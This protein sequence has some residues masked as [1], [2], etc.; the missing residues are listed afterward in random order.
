MSNSM[1]QNESPL[2]EII[3]FGGRNSPNV[4]VTYMQSVNQIQST[5]TNVF[6]K[7]T[8]QPWAVPPSYLQFAFIHLLPYAG[9]HIQHDNERML[10][11]KN[12]NA[13]TDMLMLDSKSRFIVWCFSANFGSSWSANSFWGFR[14][15]E[16][17]IPT[18]NAEITKSLRTN[19]SF[20]HLHFAFLH[21]NSALLSSNS[22]SLPAW[23][24]A[25]MSLMMLS[26]F[27]WTSNNA[28]RYLTIRSSPG[29]AAK[30]SDKTQKCIKISLLCV[31]WIKSFRICHSA[32]SWFDLNKKPWFVFETSCNCV[33]NLF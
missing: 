32:D 10:V 15:G 3:I 17:G 19:S 21:T 2:V 5:L 33:P 16:R 14:S 26:H 7:G 22:A 28:E 23:I 4:V 8:S 9:T 29:P 31:C 6:G 25:S 18:L 20:L 13:Y 27:G 11:V 30:F 1:R 12:D 24:W